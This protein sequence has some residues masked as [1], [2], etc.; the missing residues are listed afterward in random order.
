M[1]YRTVF[2]NNISLIRS[3]YKLIHAI[4]RADRIKS[5]NY[6]AA[7]TK[8]L[9]SNADELAAA[10]GEDGF[11][12]FLAD[13][14]AFT[15]NEDYIS[16]ADLLSNDLLGILFERQQDLI[17][18]HPEVYSDNF[19]ANVDHIKQHD[20]ELY[21]ALMSQM[22]GNTA[23][24]D[25]AYDVM[26]ALSGELTL[27]AEDKVKN[28][29]FRLHSAIAPFEEALSFWE[30]TN[31]D[32]Q[33]EYVFY[34]VGMG[35]YIRAAA[36]SV[37]VCFYETDIRMLVTYLMYDDIASY[38]DGKSVKIRLVSEE[39][40]IEL[41]KA[42]K[43]KRILNPVFLRAISDPLIRKKCL[44]MQYYDN[45]LVINRKTMLA[46][47]T[48]NIANYDDT[49]EVLCDRIKGKDV[50]IVGAGP[51][52]EDVLSDMKQY[53]ESK[54][55]ED[56]VI[57]CAGAALRALLNAG[58]KPDLALIADMYSVTGRQTAALHECGVPLIFSDFAAKEAIHDYEG[59]RYIICSGNIPESRAF[60]NE[61]GYTIFDNIG[62]F[63]NSALELCIRFE[64]ASICFAGV[65][66]AYDGT[67]AHAEGTYKVTDDGG[68]A[69]FEVEA[70][71]GG[72][73]Y[74]PKD[75]ILY[76]EMIEDRILQSDVKSRFFNTSLRGAAIRGVPAIGFKEYI[77]SKG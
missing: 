54:E 69:L 41:F 4:K 16:V 55:G 26:P 17:G 20:R 63:V 8:L 7:Y 76:R 33:E 39:G 6:F 28:S 43:W 51:S 12:A 75:F 24:E 30:N 59:K 68:K 60:A 48:H 50:L 57:M 47:L 27:S 23:Y 13:F 5:V 34:G 22:D 44:E 61:K 52:L 3:T 73:K 45:S 29:V 56:C 21:D 53:R 19:R 11:G 42:N 71:A 70:A 72:I 74:A 15:E 10:F 35:H 25:Y 64:A 32:S 65:D 18:E 62:D 46:N 14:V 40:L 36:G 9:E 1:G 38:Y 31:T 67:K 66:L 2:D 58:V 37:N 77:R 49:A